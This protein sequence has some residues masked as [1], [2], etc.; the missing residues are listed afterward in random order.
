MSVTEF[1]RGVPTYKDKDD[2]EFGLLCET[3]EV[4]VT[5]NDGVSLEYKLQTLMQNIASLTSELQLCAKESDLSNYL[6]KS[7]GTINGNLRVGTSGLA[8]FM[9]VNDY[10]SIY[11]QSHDNGIFQIYD[12]TNGK[13]IVESKADGTTTFNGTASGNLPLTGGSVKNQAVTLVEFENT[14][15]GAARAMLGF[16]GNGVL[17]GHLGFEGANNPVFRKTDGNYY[18]FL[19]TANSTKVVVSQTAPSDTSALWV[20]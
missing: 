2:N 7:G 11:I 15:S 4:C 9:L 16:S 5:D 18:S 6:P 3:K 19:H 13:L 10:R 20:W 17:F 12:V 8:R 1:K 14:T